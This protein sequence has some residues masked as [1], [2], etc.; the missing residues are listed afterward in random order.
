MNGLKH[1]PIT[2]TL[3]FYLNKYLKVSF[4]SDRVWKSD[5]LNLTSSSRCGGVVSPCEHVTQ[6]LIK[7]RKVFWWNSMPFLSKTN[8]NTTQY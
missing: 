5:R 3:I 6:F 8:N 7:G 2:F 4:W 1:F